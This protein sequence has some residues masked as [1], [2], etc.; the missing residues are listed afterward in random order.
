MEGDMPKAIPVPRRQ[1]AD[2]YVLPAIVTIVAVIFM[3]VLGAILDVSFP[4]GPVDSD[5]P[6]YVT[7]LQE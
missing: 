1:E 4:A 3:V 6:T 2:I 7:Q 5:A